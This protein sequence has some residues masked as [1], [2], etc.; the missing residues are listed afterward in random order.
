MEINNI[1]TNNFKGAFVLHPQNQQVREAIPDI[2]KKGRQIFHNIKS[3]G[4]VVIVTKDKY[5]KKVKEFIEREKA[6][7]AYYP[8]INTSSGLDDQI[9]SELRKLM[10]KKD[11]CVINS[12]SLLNKIFNLGLFI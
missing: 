2:V 12:L 9:P 5:D 11:N 6:A 10:L 3:E 8:E 1:S 4:D 7:F